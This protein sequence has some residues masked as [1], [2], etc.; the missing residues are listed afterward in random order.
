MKN[1]ILSLALVLSLALSVVACT[2]AD[3]PPSVSNLNPPADNASPNNPP[4]ADMPVVGL[5]PSSSD[6][7][8]WEYKWIYCF[9]PV[10]NE[11]DNSG[12]YL[13]INTGEL[14]RLGAEGWELVAIS[15][16]DSNMRVIFLFKRKLP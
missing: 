8:R 13:D 3:V 12:G 10:R 7:E 5:S 15:G 16:E 14:N 4:A 1:R 6:A 11:A 9:D 2:V